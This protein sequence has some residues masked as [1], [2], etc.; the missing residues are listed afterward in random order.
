MFES[1]C[2]PG[3]WYLWYLR[4]INLS[5]GGCLSKCR[6]KTVIDEA[7]PDSS[8]QPLNGRGGI[9]RLT[10]SGDKRKQKLDVTAVNTMN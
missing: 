4:S 5:C 2:E 1:Q 10:T 6:S 8:H 7:Y 3:V 9:I